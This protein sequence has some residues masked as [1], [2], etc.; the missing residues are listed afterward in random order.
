V[1]LTL[2]R[3]AGSIEIDGARIDAVSESEM[4]EAGTRVEVIKVIGLK[5][6][7]KA[8]PSTI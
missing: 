6:I 5:V 4:L 2:L 3:P 1:A 8:T 7:V